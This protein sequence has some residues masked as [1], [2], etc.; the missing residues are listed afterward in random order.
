MKFVVVTHCYWQPLNGGLNCLIQLAKLLNDKGHDSKVYVPPEHR[1]GYEQNA[2]YT[3]YMDHH[4]MDEERIAIYLDCILGNPLNA[5]RIVRYITYGS[6]W[7]PGYEANE[8]IYYHLPF[9]KNNP[10]KKRLTP[11]YWPSGIK[12]LGLPRTNTATYIV[13]KGSRYPDVRNTFSNTNNLRQLAAID[14]EGQSHEELIKTF[15]TTKYF[16]CYDP[17]CFLVIVAVM[18][19]CIVIQHPVAGCSAD[20]WRYM[21]EMPKNGVAYGYSDL[22][23]AESTIDLAY[24]ECLKFKRSADES[25]DNFIKDMETGNYTYEPCYKFNESPYSLQHLDR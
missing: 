12:N 9:C 21:V 18:C 13:K 6:H 1:Y 24:E 19:G 16:Y 10:A 20:E 4:E 23:R 17:C 2:I 15:N 8:M 25:V 11:T 22:A 7:Y 14:I 5:K 3:N